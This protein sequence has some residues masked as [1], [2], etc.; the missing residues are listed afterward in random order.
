[1]Q[2]IFP[3]LDFLYSQQVTSTAAVRW[4]QS[5]LYSIVIYMGEILFHI[6][7][8]GNKF[9]MKNVVIVSKIFLFT[10]CYITWGY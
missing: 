8:H 9:K 5:W 1:M 7:A 4:T 10:I 6:L 3:S 2:G